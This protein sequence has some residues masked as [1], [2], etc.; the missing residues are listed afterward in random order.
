MAAQHQ[1]LR[2]LWQSEAYNAPVSPVERSSAG[3]AHSS[4]HLSVVND[5]SEPARRCSA[6]LAHGSV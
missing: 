6:G 4:I 3:A 2:G 5:D 1:K